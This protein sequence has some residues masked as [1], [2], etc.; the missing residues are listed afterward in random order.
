MARALLI[1]FFMSSTAQADIFGFTNEEGFTSR[2]PSLVKKLKSLDMDK[3]SNYEENFNLGVKA[4]ENSIEEEKLFCSGESADSK[5]VVLP[6]EQKQLCFRELKTHYL[7]AMEEIFIL[8]KKYL[9]KIHALQ[10]QK[11]TEIQ[12]NLKSDIE[13]SF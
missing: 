7:S 13:K 3:E 10:I 11:L 8:K 9:G 6:K 1:L 5:G 4:I 12:K 2:V